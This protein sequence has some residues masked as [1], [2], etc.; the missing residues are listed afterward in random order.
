MD[1]FDQDDTVEPFHE[2]D[3]IAKPFVD[4]QV[5]RTVFTKQQKHGY[6][7]DKRRHNQGND[8]QSL[9][10]NSAT[11]IKPC[12]EI[13][14]RDRNNR[15]EQHRHTGDVKRIQERFLEQR[16]TKEI[17]KIDQS[18]VARIG[19]LKGDVDDFGDWKDEKNEQKQSD[20]QGQG[21]NTPTIL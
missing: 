9:D 17:N 3:G 6:G 15:R 14:Q 4:Q 20:A 5:H 1:G 10:Q 11:E 13:R 18:Q 2:R 16:C 12:R 7:T 21:I 8:T 19:I